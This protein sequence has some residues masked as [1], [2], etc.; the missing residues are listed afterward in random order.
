MQRICTED[1]AHVICRQS[2]ST[3]PSSLT[4]PQADDDRRDRHEGNPG[5][6]KQLFLLAQHTE[7]DN[8]YARAPLY[9][10]LQELAKGG[11]GGSPTT[12]FDTPLADL[13]PASWCVWRDQRHSINA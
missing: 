1:N 7:G 8:P 11:M 4:G 6:S 9:E 2:G 3:C 5:G 13:H 10:A 12:L